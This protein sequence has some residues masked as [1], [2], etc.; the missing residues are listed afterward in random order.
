M[1]RKWKCID[2]TKRNKL[3]TW[4]TNAMRNRKDKFEF[5]CMEMFIDPH[6]EPHNKQ[7]KTKLVIATWLMANGQWPMANDQW[8]FGH[9]HFS[10]ESNR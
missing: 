6:T 10:P 4:I 8:L 5:N 9:F 7:N 3:L 1:T 2:K